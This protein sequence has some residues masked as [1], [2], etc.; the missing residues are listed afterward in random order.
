MET[1]QA[2]S[3]PVL[4]SSSDLKQSEDLF[5]DDI[6]WVDSCLTRDLEVLGG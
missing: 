2:Q 4:L 6:A 3:P 1:L 5:H